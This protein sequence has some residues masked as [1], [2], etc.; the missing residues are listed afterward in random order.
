MAT[1]RWI[2]KAKQVT[3]VDKIAISGSWASTNT[4]TVKING[5]AAVLTVGALTTTDQVATSLKQAWNGE[6]LTDTSAS[7]SPTI[8]DG[9]FKSI[10][11]FSEVTASILS[12]ATS[13]VVL[14]ANTSGKPFTVDSVVDTASGAATWSS[15]TSCTGKWWW[16]NADNWSLAAT[17]ANGDDIVFDS[18]SVD[19]KYGLSTGIQPLSLRITNGY[20]GSIGLPVIN[21]ENTS[22]RYPEYRT[23][24]VTFNNNS[25]TNTI[26]IGE[27]DGQGARRL[28]IDSGAGRTT[29]FVLHT[30]ARADT[31]APTL[32]WKGTHV[33]N[34]VTIEQ[35]D[36]GIAYLPGETATVATLRAG[37]DSGGSV[38]M[39]C[40]SGVTLTTV[41]IAGAVSGVFNSGCTTFTCTGKASS[42][43]WWSGAP[44]TLRLW[45]G[46]FKE[47]GRAHV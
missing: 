36:M 16:S 43:E 26:T 1:N 47:I 3:Q 35:G 18:G 38:A 39:L 25:I 33:S 37:T 8:A 22:K 21:S 32:A 11:E 12:S 2:G 28:N 42:V 30:A 45:S 5:V 23:R 44:A 24:Y 46:V 6:T 40:G 27:L 29:L 9:G 15:V 34:D 19:C 31:D 17:P 13:E 14:T 41:V 7:C 20:S 4:I 10:P